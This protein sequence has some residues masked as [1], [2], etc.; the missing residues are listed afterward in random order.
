MLPKFDWIP[1]FGVG[2]RDEH[3]NVNLILCFRSKNQ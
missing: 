3:V 1:D 2:G